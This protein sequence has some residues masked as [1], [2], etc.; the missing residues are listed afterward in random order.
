M[1]TV[2][3]KQVINWL[4]ETCMNCVCGPYNSGRCREE[5]KVDQ[6]PSV[7]RRIRSAFPTKEA[8]YDK[9]L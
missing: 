5:E 1:S 4:D 7:V 8:L 3:N 9:A 2:E 6:C